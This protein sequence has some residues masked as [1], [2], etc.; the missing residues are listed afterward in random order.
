MCILFAVDEIRRRCHPPPGRQANNVD[1]FPLVVEVT[2][3]T[4][5]PLVT[6]F[7]ACRIL[8]DP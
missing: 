2:S 5:K 8:R 3:G 7:C 1:A 6:F 4:A